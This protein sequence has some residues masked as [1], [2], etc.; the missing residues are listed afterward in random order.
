MPFSLSDDTTLK[1]AVSWSRQLK[2]GKPAEE[3]EIEDIIRNSFSIKAFVPCDND[4][5]RDD[6]M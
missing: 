1:S 2:G 4:R 6:V 5:P 3:Q